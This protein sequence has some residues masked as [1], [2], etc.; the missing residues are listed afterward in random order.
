VEKEKFIEIITENQN[1]IYKI[2]NS[3]C[4]DKEGRKDLEQEILLQLWKSLKKFDGRVKITTWIYK[5]A[6]NTA[7]SCYRK[8]CKRL[9]KP[10]DFD[11]SIISL[12][13]FEYDSSIEEKISVLYKLLNKLGS[14]ERAL[15]LLYLDD[16]KHKEIAEILA[17]S[18]SNVATKI[19][20]IKMTLREQISNY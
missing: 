13:D 8:D 7:I 17:I 9:D 16:Y 5:I 2:C 3:Y 15:M 19:S 14:M 6:L 12:S 4:S 1:L 20:R 18:E 10:N 11:I